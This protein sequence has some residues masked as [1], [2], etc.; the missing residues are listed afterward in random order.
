MNPLV[1]ALRT[2]KHKRFEW[3]TVRHEE[4]GA[5][6]SGT[7]AKLTG[8]LGLCVE[9][10]GPG[11][12]YLL[13]R[14]YDTK[15]E[16]APVLALTVQTPRDEIGRDYHEEINLDQLFDDISVYNETV[17]PPPRANASF[18]F[19]SCANGVSASRGCS[20][21]RSPSD[22]GTLPKRCEKN[23]HNPIP[24]DSPKK[25]DS[26]L[27]KSA[28]KTLKMG[29]YFILKRVSHSNKN[30]VRPQ[31]L[32]HYIDYYA[33]KDA[34]STA[35]TSKPIISMRRHIQ[36]KGRRDFIASFNLASMANAFIQAIG[37][38]SA[39][40]RTFG[41]HP[42]RRWRLYDTYGRFY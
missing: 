33:S 2:D 18:R 6:A 17:I 39:R 10:V 12:V 7:Q 21:Y 22:I 41:S 40:P 37:I 42:L 13:N 23:C 15:Y 26:H 3:I 27:K 16:Y 20:C 1:D 35:D 36:M 34:V 4:T 8:K 29:H 38:T 19:I 11:V 9:T 32:A 25:H 14:L 5:F 31:A 28:G 30:Y 24:H